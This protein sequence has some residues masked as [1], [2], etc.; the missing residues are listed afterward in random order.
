[1]S[2]TFKKTYSS[3]ELYEQI[4]EY[5]RDGIVQV[6]YEELTYLQSTSTYTLAND[7]ITEITAIEGINKDGYYIPPTGTFNN[8][9]AL[10][11]NNDYQLTYSGTQTTDPK[12]NVLYSNLVFNNASQFKNNSKVF[13]SYK[14]YDSTR[15]SNITNFQTG[16]VAGM[17]ARNLANQLSNLYQINNRTYEAGFLSLAKGN[18]LDNHADGWGLTRQNG[19]FATGIIKLTIGSGGTT[20]VVNNNYV[21]V[22]AIAGQTLGFQ[23]TSPVTGFSYETAPGT[24]SYYNVQAVAIGSKYNIGANTVS[25]LYNSASFATDVT[26]DANITVSNP[27]LTND[28]LLNTF[29]GGQDIETDDDLRTRIY[30]KANK[31]GRASLPAMKAALEDLDFVKNVK[32]LDYETNPDLDADTFYVYAVGDSGLKLL[33]DTTSKTNLR[34]E[35]NEYR[36]VGTQFSILSPMGI[37]I[38]FSGTATLFQEDGINTTQT[39]SAIETNITNYI[40]NL[41]IGEDVIYSQLIEEAMIVPGVYKFEINKLDYTEFATNPYAFNN[42]D[43]KI[44]DN[45]TGTPTKQWYRQDFK[46][47]P[48]LKTETKLYDGNTTYTMTY[49]DIVNSPSPYVL[50]SIQD[51]DGNYIRDP[52]YTTNWY[53]SNSNNSITINANAG[54]GVGRTLATNVDYLTFYYENAGTDTIDKLRVKLSNNYSTASHSGSVELYIYSGSSSPTDLVDQATITILSGT[55]DYEVTL[56]GGS[57]T[58]DDARTGVYYA[59][60]SGINT[61]SGTYISLP[62]S[63]SGT[64]G[65]L[66][67][68]LYSGAGSTAITSTGKLV[69]NVSPLLHTIITTSGTADIPIE[70][71]AQTPDVAVVY[72]IDLSYNLISRDD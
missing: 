32:I 6:E 64:T 42:T 47:L 8:V 38:N 63:L 21:A 54:T 33:T 17:L 11:N 68:Q 22:S 59:I 57:L 49:S 25:I 4:V 2:S 24:S 71:K 10:V 46:W 1:M 56:D 9:S 58:V 37:F 61:S 29:S 72:D 36:P 28:G 34:N 35:I 48:S 3:D 43:Q 23:I 31:L 13:V 39:L 67:T 53:T 7:N 51:S 16:S 55:R 40:N 70:K 18:D 41:Q 12:N 5:L 27:I 20:L 62:V 50:L 19:A 69:P 52:S 44:I 15:L 45:T 30:R 60:F 65:A 26:A 14:Y 66:N